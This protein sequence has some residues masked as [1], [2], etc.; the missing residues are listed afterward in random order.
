MRNK[1]FLMYFITIS[2]DV[3]YTRIK[4]APAK[5]HKEKEAA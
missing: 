5:V 2:V 1:D 4:F 3:Y